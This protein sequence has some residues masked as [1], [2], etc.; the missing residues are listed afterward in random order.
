MS[1]SLSYLSFHAG[2]QHL[3]IELE[4]RGW[5][6]KKTKIKMSAGFEAWCEFYAD[7]YSGVRLAKAMAPWTNCTWRRKQDL[8]LVQKWARFWWEYA[9]AMWP[10]AQAA[11]IGYRH[12]PLFPH[13]HGCVSLTGLS[14]SL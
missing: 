14:R 1:K 2:V 3:E 9:R 7:Q 8:T 6:V 4:A 11:M 12:P 13:E 10:R 5:S